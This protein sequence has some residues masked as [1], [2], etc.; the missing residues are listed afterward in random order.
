MTMD[1]PIIFESLAKDLANGGTWEDVAEEL[2]KAGW[3][4]FVD[5]AR[6]K[7]LVS[8]YLVAKNYYNGTKKRV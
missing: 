8:P 6:A 3:L 4:P 5:I 1:I 2:C 7:R